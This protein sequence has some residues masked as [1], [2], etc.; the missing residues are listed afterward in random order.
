MDNIVKFRLDPDHINA[1]DRLAAGYSTTRSE[2]IRSLMLPRLALALGVL[3]SDV[4]AL[5]GSRAPSSPDA[6]PIVNTRGDNGGAGV[7]HD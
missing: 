2:I 4:D 3:D 6:L 5:S 1:L 7:S